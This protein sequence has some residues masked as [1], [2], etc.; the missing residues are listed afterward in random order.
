M[1]KIYYKADSGQHDSAMRWKCLIH[2]FSQL[3]VLRMVQKKIQ[4]GVKRSP[5]SIS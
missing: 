1:H 4:L 2:F 5:L 3:F